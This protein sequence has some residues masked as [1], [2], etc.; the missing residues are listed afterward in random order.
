MTA[1]PVRRAPKRDA[2]RPPESRASL[3]GALRRPCRAASSPVGVARSGGNSQ[4][5]RAGGLWTASA[6]QSAR[7]PWAH[8]GMDERRVRPHTSAA[9]RP[10]RAT[11][12]R[13]AFSKSCGSINSYF[14][15]RFSKTT[16]SRRPQ[17]GFPSIIQRS[18]FRNNEISDTYF[19][20]ELVESPATLND[21]WG[22]K[23]FDQNWKSTADVLR[24]KQHLAE[25][26]M[27]YLLNIGPDH[28]GRFSA[29][30]IAVLKEV[31]AKIR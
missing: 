5:R 4:C 23:A 22:Y 30:T 27:N 21:T 7:R 3:R 25:R 19:N 8:R 17:S 14:G 12:T 18:V 31:G 24:I 29:P 15:V 20:E 6:T 13:A 10:M 11:L 16:T 1:A 9:T 26:G 2:Q 28:L